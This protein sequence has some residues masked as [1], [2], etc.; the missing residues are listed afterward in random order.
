MSYHSQ[1]K[2]ITGICIHSCMWLQERFQD[3]YVPSGLSRS[4]ASMPR[5]AILCFTADAG[6]PIAFFCVGVGRDE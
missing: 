1:Q 5:S 6:T 4:A 3:G 2:F